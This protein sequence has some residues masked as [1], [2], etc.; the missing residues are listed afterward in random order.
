M[1]SLFSKPKAQSAP[2]VEEIKDT[3]EEDLKRRRA[4]YETEEGILGEEVD[5]VGVNKRKGLFGN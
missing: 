1:G 3:S 2:V 4:L 5:K